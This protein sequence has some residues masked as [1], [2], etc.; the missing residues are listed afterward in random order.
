MAERK[1]RGQ[2]VRS[3]I[4]MSRTEVRSNGRYDAEEWRRT[5]LQISPCVVR[6]LFPR[7]TAILDLCDNIYTGH[8]ASLQ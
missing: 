8:Q 1:V 4:F 7:A 5:I 3:A 2:A 6:E